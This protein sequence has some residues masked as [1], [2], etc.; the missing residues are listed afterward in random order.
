[1]KKLFKLGFMPLLLTLFVHL[2][3]Q[4]DFRLVADAQETIE[5][6][7]IGLTVFP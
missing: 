5:F 1:M 4:K 7:D 6:S 3:L 2:N